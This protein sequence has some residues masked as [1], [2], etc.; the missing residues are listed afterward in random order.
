VPRWEG[1]A[2]DAE[3]ERIARELDRHAHTLAGLRLSG[4]E[5]RAIQTAAAKMLADEALLMNRARRAQW[6]QTAWGRTAIAIGGCSV[7][8]QLFNLLHSLGKL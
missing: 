5:R 1:P 4:D 6:W 8:V 3:H 7:L 2:H